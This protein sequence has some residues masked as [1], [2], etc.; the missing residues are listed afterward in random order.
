M[1]RPL[2]DFNQR[3][4]FE[5]LANSARLSGQGAPPSPGDQAMVQICSAERVL[6]AGG[7]IT[8]YVTPDSIVPFEAVYR[9]LPVDG[10]FEATPSQPVQF[11]MGFFQVPQTMA[12]VLLDW[13]FDIYR[14]SGAAAGDYVPLEP[15][16]LST[17]VGWNIQSNQ[18]VQGNFHYELNPIPAAQSRPSYQSN[19]NPGFIPGGPGTPATDDQF[20]AA[21]FQ[22]V[23][24]ASGDLSILPQRHHRQGLMPCP[25]PWSLHSSSSLTISCHVFRAIQIPIAFFEAEVFGFLIPDNDLLAL[26]K[27]LQPCFQKP[28]GV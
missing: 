22:Q 26:Q 14:P 4:A 27:V 23:Q 11:D 9:R 18:R 25:A 15:N 6:K 19:P 12:L 28:G 20:T 2:L 1:N 16:R 5:S 10:I 7:E 21:R 13:H 8:G 3:S 17:Q 24:A